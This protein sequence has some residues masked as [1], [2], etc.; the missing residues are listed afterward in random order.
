MYI[1]NQQWKCLRGQEWW[2]EKKGELLYPEEPA[3]KMVKRTMRIDSTYRTKYGG[4]HHD[5]II[6][7]A[8]NNSV[9]LALRRVFRATGGSVETASE[10]RKNQ[11][12]FISESQGFLD[13]LRAMYAKTL[14]DFRG[15]LV[16]AEEHYKDPHAKKSLR[17][18]AWKDL[19]ERGDMSSP[20]WCEY[21]TYKLKKDEWAKPG[22]EPR[23]IGDL[24]VPASLQGFMVTKY[25]KE[26]MK[27][28]IHYKDGIMHFCASPNHADL[29]EVFDELRQPTKRAYIAYFSDDS[30]VAVRNGGKVERYN[31]DITSCDAS[32]TSLLFHALI[33]LARG[34]AADNLRVLVEQLRVP[35]R[36]YDLSRPA[37]GPGKRYSLFRRKGKEPTL[38]SGSTITTAIN[39]L[40][41]I[42]IG[43]SIIET[44]ATLPEEIIAAAKAV[45]YIVTLTHC[46]IIED[47]QFLK[48]SPVKDIHG[49]Y[50]PVMNLGVLLRT[51]G[52][53]KGDVPGRTKDGFL[54]RCRA[55]D[56]G[57]LQGLYPRT[58]FPFVDRKKHVVAGVRTRLDKQVATRIGRL[59]EHRVGTTETAVFTSEDIYRRY[60][61]TPGE[62]G[63][64]DEEIAY[65]P[66]N[67]FH[68]CKAA[69]KILTLDYGLQSPSLY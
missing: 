39:N 29:Q 57:I 38:Y 1:Y 41:N 64:M 23:M 25:L 31:M 5:G 14:D 24:K 10:Y 4:F 37:H 9:R 18:Q 28:D 26:A 7:E 30:C 48:H 52:T 56:R 3:L 53:A 60:R 50:R 43:K 65:A 33:N 63:V 11:H 69:S 58:S 20:L 44:G 34:A 59:L 47:L 19:F 42:L 68:S 6:Y 16:E 27:E 8:S 35:M 36:V 62:I 22:K 66:F 40:A 55:F 13:D 46:E 15:F 49:V 61:L 45:G 51:I 32:H 12:N 67:S 2:D 17:E 21:V 54:E